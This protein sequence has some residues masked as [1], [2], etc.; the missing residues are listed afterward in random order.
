MYSTTQAASRYHQVFINFEI[1][2]AMMRRVNEK[3]D[4]FVSQSE[5]T[6]H[7][8]GAEECCAVPRPVLMVPNG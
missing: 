1:M 8:I 7:S 5:H 6:E 3:R 4:H 2:D